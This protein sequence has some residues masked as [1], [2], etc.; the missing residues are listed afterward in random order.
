VTDPSPA[1]ATRTVE[2]DLE[3]F[4]FD[5]DFLGH[6]SNIAYIR[7]LEIAR[8]R[9]LEDMGLPVPTL[10]RE[11]VVPIVI[12][13]EIDYR[14]PV[15]LGD[16]VHLSMHLCD[17]RSLTATIAFRL[18]VGDVVVATAQQR[19]LFI[20]TSTGKPR[21]ISAERKAL[22]ERYLVSGV[23]RGGSRAR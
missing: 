2:M 10:A 5:I 17:L 13:T 21:R 14:L 23:S 20:D 4:T 9:L 1:S 22:F 12:R 19:G 18:T 11:G 16:A 15:E 6:V 7:W 3:V 8:L